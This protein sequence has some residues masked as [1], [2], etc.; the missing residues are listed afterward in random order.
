[1]RQ[2]NVCKQCM[3]KGASGMD[4]EFVSLLP[5][6]LAPFSVRAKEVTA[7]F[8]LQNK[9]CCAILTSQPTKFSGGDCKTTIAG[10]RTSSVMVSFRYTMSS[11]ASFSIGA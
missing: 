10:K 2:T 5:A 8:G 11:F 3:V 7:F 9:R 1:M 6:L 4:N